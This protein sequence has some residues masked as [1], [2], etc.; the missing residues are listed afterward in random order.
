MILQL[1][2]VYIG[3]PSLAVAA[4]LFYFTGNPPTGRFEGQDE[5]GTLRNTS[6]GV[7]DPAMTSISYYL[8]FFGVRQMTTLLM[9]L[10]TQLILIDYLAI[11]RGYLFRF[12]A[13]IPLFVM[14]ARGWP[15]VLFA[16]SLYDWALL[17]GQHPFFAHWLYFQKAVGLFNEDNP[18][19]SLVDS[20]WN[21]RVLALASTVPVAVAIKRFWM[22][23]FLGKQTYYQYSDKLAVVMKKILLITQVATLSRQVISNQGRVHLKARGGTVFAVL[24]Q[25][26]IGDMVDFADEERSEPHVDETMSNKSGT[27]GG[28]NNMILDPEDR[29]PL[30]GKLSQVQKNR[31]VKL[32][33]VW[34]EPT[35]VARTNETISI[36]SLM[37][38]RR[39]V[40]SLRTD[41]PFSASFGAAGTR[42]DCIANAQ[43]VFRRLMLL[44]ESDDTLD[45]EVL[46]LLGAKSDGTL[47]HEKLMEL[48]KLFRPDRDGSLSIVQ[49][50][51]SV[52]NVYKEIRLLRASVSNSTRV[53]AAFVVSLYVFGIDPL[54]LFVSVSG[55]VVSV[56]FMIGSASS[57]YFQGLIFILI[58]CP[59]SIGDCIHVSTPTEETVIT[60]SPFWIVE[61]ITL[62]ATQVR[63]S[64]TN[65]RASLSNGALAEARIINSTK[66]TNASVAHKMK[67]PINVSHEKI[68]IFQ[69]AMER[70]IRNRPREWLGMKVFRASEVNATLGY[71]EYVVSMNHRESW[72]QWG[73]IRMSQSDIMRFAVELAKKLDI[74]YEQ[75][76]QP[77]NF[78]NSLS[79]HA[80]QGQQG[81]LLPELAH[82][83]LDRGVSNV[84]ARSAMEDSMSG[85]LFQSLEAQFPPRAPTK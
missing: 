25:Q 50:V 48:I 53:D 55:I 21:R 6:G 70:F 36:S 61:D 60:G 11:D 13:R 52:D 39:A 20:E 30:T 43:V 1:I 78:Q 51:R 42:E 40:R 33:G 81:L 37:H 66:S 31:I 46:A 69:E 7:I 45:F 62:F 29:N 74:V 27:V 26:S 12:G 34:E 47:D 14:Q 79:V 72:A 28:A 41:L 54:A 49:F 44:S 64:F 18:D 9:A 59:Y 83:F 4:I 8:L 15:F 56:S 63:F 22:G 82:P 17:S 5:D 10:G 16:W 38:F 35:E 77:I 76:A 68:A 71:I 65:E 32:L 2:I 75:P 23:I 73:Q 19:G 3:F 58:R 24:S 67:F 85:S 80:P 84:S 57:S